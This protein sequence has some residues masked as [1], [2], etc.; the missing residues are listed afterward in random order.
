MPFRT[1]HD[2]HDPRW[3]ALHKNDYTNE[4]LQFYDE[5]AVRTNNGVLTITPKAKSVTFDALNDDTKKYHKKTK[6]FTSGMIQ[7]WNKFCFTGG[8]VEVRA[9]LPGEAYRDCGQQCG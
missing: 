1:F 3:T 2:G 4:A 8:I 9:K 5:N 6:H 7:S